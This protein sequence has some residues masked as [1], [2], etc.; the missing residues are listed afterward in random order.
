MSDLIRELHT[1]VLHMPDL[2]DEVLRGLLEKL[3]EL[4]YD[5]SHETSQNL[6]LGCLVAMF[7]EART[8]TFEIL[9]Q[10]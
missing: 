3:A 2:P 10:A 7:Q 9:N 8:R 6:Q 1:F 5:L 4:E